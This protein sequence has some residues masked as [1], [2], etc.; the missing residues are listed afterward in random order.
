MPSLVVQ[1][2]CSLAVLFVLRRLLRKN[3]YPPPPGP[4]GLPI[5]GNLWDIPRMPTWVA[6]RDWS[7]KYGEYLLESPG[8][9]ND[10]G[11][12]SDIVRY[13]VLG[14]NIIVLNSLQA[15][16]DLLEKRSA[17]Y[18]DRYACHLVLDGV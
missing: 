11:K 6:Y 15:V 7:K 2:V 16:T 1:V 14:N 12:G 4:P 13:N 10:V 8:G 18:S 9:D 17:I 3:A 5:V